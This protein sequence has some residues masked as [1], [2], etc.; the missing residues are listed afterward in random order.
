MRPVRTALAGLLAGAV[1][2][3]FGVAHAAPANAADSW[4]VPRDARIVVTGHGYGH[5]HG[6]SQY[7]AEGAARAGLTYREIV[8][9]YYPGT[10]WTRHRGRIEVLITA[11]TSDDVVVVAE[12]ELKVRSLEQRRTWQ[13]PDGAQRWRLVARR[14]GR[15]QVQ[16]LDGGSWHGWKRFAGDG[17][18]AGGGGTLELVL[19]SGSATYRG[20]LRAASPTPGGQARDTV[21][22]VGLESYL[23][24][25]VA[26]E[27]PAT[28]SP[29]AVRAQAVAAR[30]YAAYERRHPRGDHFQVYD[31][32]S[33][34]VYG[35]V[36]AEHPDS[37]AAIRA[38]R[39]QGLEHQGEP[40]L[41]QFSSSN[42]GWSSAGD[43]S[44]LVAQEDPYDGWDGN[45]NHDWSVRFTDRDLERAWPRVGNLRRVVVL[46]REETGAQWGGRVE[47]LRLRGSRAA[48]TISGDDFR[49]KMGLMSNWF[50]FRVRSR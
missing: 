41:T 31:T 28:W 27:M 21:N 13:L 15:T 44:Y 36:A 6:M 34:Q 32:V 14:D 24:G 43:A 10:E 50:T 17:Q 33:S 7:G 39:W 11:D 45:P 3:T 23:R 48:V 40:A 46:E 25:V 8:D 29:E 47:R 2:T 19:P 1:A 38:T 12:P 4:R 20:R 49:W 26:R 9:F 42:G 22:V 35:G 5:G 30:T 37:D 16:Y 18:F